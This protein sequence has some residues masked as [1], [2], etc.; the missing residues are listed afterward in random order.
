MKCI[1]KSCP[2]QLA[3]CMGDDSCK[4]CYEAEDLTPG[5]CLGIDM[6][7]DLVDCALCGCTD[8]SKMEFCLN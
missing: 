8:E 4:Q 2:V 3:V 6:F 5:L 7:N 1:E